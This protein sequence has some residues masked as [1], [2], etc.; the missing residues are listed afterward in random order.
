MQAIV[1]VSPPKEMALTHSVLEVGGLQ[2]GDDRLRHRPLA[3]Y[4]EVVCRAQGHL[5]A[6]IQEVTEL[7]L[8]V[9]ADLFLAPAGAGKEDRGGGGLRSSDPLLV[10]MCCLGASLG[11]RQNIFKRRSEVGDG[12]DAP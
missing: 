3:R 4:V 2:E 1:S 5:Q 9:A 11:L 10:I 7:L 8:R 6:L 12:A